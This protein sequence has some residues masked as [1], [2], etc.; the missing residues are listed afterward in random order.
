MLFNGLL[1][2][3]RKDFGDERLAGYGLVDVSAGYI[4]PY[5]TVALKVDNLFDKDYELAS[6][7]NTPGQSLYAELRLRLFE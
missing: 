1:T 6:G 2:S 3:D 5:A 7:F 4:F